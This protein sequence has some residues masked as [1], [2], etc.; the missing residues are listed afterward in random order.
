MVQR[1]LTDRERTEGSL[2]T[3]VHTQEAVV[4]EM[5]ALYQSGATLSEVGQKFGLSKTTVRNRFRRL[6][7]AVRSNSEA[8]TGRTQPDV[9][10][11]ILALHRQYTEGASL[12]AVAAEHGLSAA[13]LQKAFVARGLEIRP[14]ARRAHSNLRREQIAALELWSNLSVSERGELG[15]LRV[16]DRLVMEGMNVWFPLQI[17]HRVDLLASE[18]D[19]ACALQVKSASYDKG[20][21]RFRLSVGTRDRN[22][23]HVRYPST[24]HDFVIV[25]C[26]GVDAMYVLTRCSLSSTNAMNLLPHRPR[27]T[28]AGIAALDSLWENELQRWDAIRTWLAEELEASRR[29]VAPQVSA[30][31]SASAM[32]ARSEIVGWAHLDSRTK[33]TLAELRAA[34]I[35][36]E[37]G[38]D[39]W[40]PLVRSSE[41]DLAVLV[42]RRLV[43]VQVK[44]ATYDLANDHYRAALTRGRHKAY[45]PG[46]FEIFMIICPGTDAAYI[47]PAD[48]VEGR[49]DLRLMPHRERRNEG[50]HELNEI[51]RNAFHLIQ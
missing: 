12:D 29:R 43:R 31:V 38:F 13:Y 46:M 36:L 17:N 8:H 26:P 49:K 3:E 27:L 14:I 18:D 41:A 24:D 25:F 1:C 28:N 15:E 2:G 16:A 47:V 50:K 33:G 22:G 51:Y 7:L 44:A 35:L 32:H 39:V 42:G 40:R 6:G 9:D 19:C 30:D 23:Q 20:T 11:R 5:Y 34:S 37:T 48:A 21:D 4:R 10:R 45:A